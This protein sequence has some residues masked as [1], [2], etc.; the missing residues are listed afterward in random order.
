MG[1]ASDGRAGVS[2]IVGVWRAG[3]IGFGEA[4]DMI[5]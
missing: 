2:T 3:S 1:V 5:A 4:G